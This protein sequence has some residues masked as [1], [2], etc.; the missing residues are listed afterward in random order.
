MTNKGEHINIEIQLKDEY[1]MIKRS[2]IIGV[3]YMKGNLKMEKT[4]RNYQERSVLIYWTL[5]Y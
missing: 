3:S 4:I 2:Y 1:N 5:I